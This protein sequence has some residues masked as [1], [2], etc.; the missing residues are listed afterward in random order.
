[1][2]SIDLKKNEFFKVITAHQAYIVVQ[3][4]DFQWLKITLL[5]SIQDTKITLENI[6]L[7]E[8]EYDKIYYFLE[9]HH[10]NYSKYRRKNYFSVKGALLVV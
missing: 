6:S 5:D 2:I 9:N 8:L 7:E 4:S 1:M 10:E 3:S